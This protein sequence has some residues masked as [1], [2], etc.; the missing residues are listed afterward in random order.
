MISFRVGQHRFH[1]R[2]AAIVRQGDHILL[3]RLLTDDFWA[4]PGGRVNPGEE[5]SD[6]I[7]REFQEELQIGVECQGLVCVGENFFQYG[8]E[9]HHEVGFYFAAKIAASSAIADRHRVH[10]GVEGSKPLE[11]RWFELGELLTI[12]MRPQA[13]Q[14]A[15]ASGSVPLHFVQ[16]DSYAA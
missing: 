8:S 6:T 11:F 4:L 16:H 3:H 5:A 2:A 15:L 10:L 13:L 9:P 7:V 1:Y 12:D 14:R